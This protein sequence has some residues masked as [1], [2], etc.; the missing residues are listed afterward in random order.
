M[1]GQK[2][3]DT[4]R[5]PYPNFPFRLEYEENKVKKVCHFECKEHLDKY[6]ERHKLKKNKVK[7]ENRK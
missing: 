7:I 2:M 5:F 6:L 3:I 4:V 1:V